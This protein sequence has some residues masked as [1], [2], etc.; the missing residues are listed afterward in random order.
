MSKDKSDKDSADK[1]DKGS[2]DKGSTDKGSS[3]PGDHWA[4]SSDVG[5]MDVCGNGS[6]YCDRDGLWSSDRD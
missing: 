1:S 6:S 4:C 3:Y 5:G 2:T